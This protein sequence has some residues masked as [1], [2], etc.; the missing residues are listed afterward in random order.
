M[1]K[2]LLTFVSLL[3]ITPLAHAQ[4]TE[5]LWDIDGHEYEIAIQDLYEREIIKGND[6][7]GSYRPDSPINRA[8]FTMILMR[9]LLSGEENISEAFDFNCFPDIP[10]GQWYTKPVCYAKDQAIVAGR[11]K[12]N[13]H[14]GDSTNFAEAAKIIVNALSV[15]VPKNSEI[16][17]SQWY[18]E[19]IYTLSELN[20]IPDTISSADQ[21]ITR[22]E[23]A[24]MIYRLLNEVTDQSSAP[25]ENFKYV[26]PD[27]LACIDKNVPPTVDMKKIRSEWLRWTNEARAAEGLP[28]YQYHDALHY[29]GRVWSEHNANI[30]LATM[31]HQRPGDTGY[32]DFYSIRDWFSNLGITFGGSSTNFTENITWGPF[33]CDGNEGDCTDQVLKWTKSSFDNFLAEVPPNDAHRRSIL[34]SGFEW[35]G[36]GLAVDE[37]GNR[38]YVTIH[39]G[40][41]VATQPGDFCG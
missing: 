22:G 2:T 31:T 37:T 15:P 34:H 29:S 40:K 32:Y 21:K 4:Q 10:T 3:L 20:A 24:E 19:F 11:P 26:E 33:S 7:D 5:P 8:E 9:S 16:D 13:F 1:K 17:F 18:E 36:F 27:N 14:P 30:G 35:I 23:M 39:Y 38:Y 41:E 12:G 6:E 28:A 25:F